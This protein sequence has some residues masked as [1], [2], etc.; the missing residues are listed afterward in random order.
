[1]EELLIS[2]GQWLRPYQSQCAMAIIATMLVLFGQDITN[3]IRQLIK[4]QH[5]IIRT[6][7]FI[8]VCAFGYGMATIWLTGALSNLFGQIKNLYFLPTVIVA[9]IALGL[10]AQ[11]Q[12]HI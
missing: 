11:K 7:I 9:F 6:V 5:I 3:A 10:Y 2:G 1:M 4:S 8:L 12:R